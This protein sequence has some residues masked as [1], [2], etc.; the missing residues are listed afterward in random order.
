MPGK[1]LNS[2][3]L[4]GLLLPVV[5]QLIL[6]PFHPFHPFLHFT[7]PDRSQSSQLGDHEGL[8]LQKLIDY[9]EGFFFVVFHKPEDIYILDQ[10]F[11]LQRNQLRNITCEPPLH[12]SDSHPWCQDPPQ[13]GRAAS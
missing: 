2:P 3:S 7:I 6:H 10:T 9:L 1:F 13:G 11:T 4:P 12:S 8:V 5:D